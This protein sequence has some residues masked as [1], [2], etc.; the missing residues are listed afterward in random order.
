M[1]PLEAVGPRVTIGVKGADRVRWR[2]AGLVDRAAVNPCREEETKLPGPVE[3]LGARLLR[4][5]AP[6]PASNCLR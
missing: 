5:R 1:P 6:M 2:S 3:S 4:G